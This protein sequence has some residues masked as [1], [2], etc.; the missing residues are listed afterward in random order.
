MKLNF[1]NLWR[2]EF[3]SKEIL[4]KRYCLTPSLRLKPYWFRSTVLNLGRM[5]GLTLGN[6]FTM[7]WPRC[8]R[9]ERIL[10]FCLAF[11]VQI[12]QIHSRLIRCLF[13][14]LLVS[15]KTSGIVS[16]EASFRISRV[17]ASSNSSPSIETL[18]HRLVWGQRS[19][20]WSQ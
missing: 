10:M 12:L 8:L 4:E 20:H 5:K 3:R 17:W 9:K 19:Y 18:R 13:N 2:T 6:V 15:L 11:V 14:L 7:A 1:E 16:Q